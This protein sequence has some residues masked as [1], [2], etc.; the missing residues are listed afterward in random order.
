MILIIA[1]ILNLTQSVKATAL[2][3]C[4]LLNGSLSCDLSDQKNKMP[5]V[6]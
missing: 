4:L 1:L 6:E 2:F 3:Q 5:S